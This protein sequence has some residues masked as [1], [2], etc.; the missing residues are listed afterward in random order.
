MAAAFLFCS[1]IMPF[2]CD[3]I[4]LSD[5]RRYFKVRESIKRSASFRREEPM[6][7]MVAIVEDWANSLVAYARKGQDYSYG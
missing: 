2:L 5:P 4:N 1:L 3:H 6:L 7:A